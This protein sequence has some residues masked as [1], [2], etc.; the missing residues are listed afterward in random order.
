[1]NIYTKLLV[2]LFLLFSLFGCSEKRE[3][4]ETSSQQDVVQNVVQEVATSEPNRQNKKIA[5]LVSDLR[6]PFGKSWLMASKAVP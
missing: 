1:M 5:Y 6:I 4:N 2:L 3:K